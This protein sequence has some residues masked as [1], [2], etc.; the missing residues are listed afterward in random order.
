MNPKL[1]LFLLIVISTSIIFITDLFLMSLIFITVI[2]IVLLLKIHTRLLEWIKPILIVSVFVIILQSFTH[3][4]IKFTTEGFLFGIMISL[5]LL[6]LLT[7]VFTLVSTTKPKELTDGLSFLPREIGLMLMLSL[8]L[9]PVVKDVIVKIMNAQ[10]VRGLNFRSPNIFKTY[11]PI[12]VPL[13]SKTLEGSN[14][15]ALAMEAR[16]FEIK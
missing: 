1:K 7:L 9:L 13:F 6:T 15:L 5:R 4:P 12:L 16:G 11:F 3:T 14:R 8:T 2:S 10:R